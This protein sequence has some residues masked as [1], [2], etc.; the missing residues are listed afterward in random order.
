[1]K[2]MTLWLGRWMPLAVLLC[3]VVL[4]ACKR[5][6]YEAPPPPEVTVARPV[7]QD[8]TL[9][10]E[11]TGTT[12]AVEAADVRAR[13]KGFLVSME[14][15]PGQLVEQD[16]LLFVI[17]PQPFEVALKAAQAELTAHRAEMDL[18]QTEYER[19]DQ[20]YKRKATSEF[21]VVKTRANYE[22]AK[23]A[24]LESEANVQSAQL[25]LDYAHVKA[26]FAGRVDRHQVDVGNLVG[27]SEA[28]LLTKLVRY[29][30]IYVYF[31]ISE[32][33]LL[34]L[35]DLG[36]RRRPERDAAAG[37]R[38]PIP[39]EV[40]RANDT[41]YPF[42]GVIDFTANQ[43]DANT[44]TFEVRGVLPNFE[45]S[46]EVIVPGTFVRVRVPIDVRSDSML[47]TERALG[48]DQGGRYLLVVGEDDIVE[49]RTVEVGQS[50]GGMRVIRSG[51]EPND[52]VVVNGLQRAR[53]GAAVRP[54]Q[55]VAEP[56]KLP[57]VIEPPP[58]A[59]PLATQTT[60]EADTSAVD[61]VDEEAADDALDTA[62]DAPAAAE[63]PSEP[64][65]A[66]TPP[67]EGA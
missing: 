9:Y 33:D 48:A 10:L 26:P 62:V 39:I 7:V 31:Y 20:M 4:G 23:A 49:H 28:T 13:V 46:D 35:Q 38:D 16:Q 17:D 61:P 34:S 3:V 40:G 12:R 24:V 54:E 30:P 64:E 42:R 22:K 18:A 29:D 32:R 44:G 50:V 8:V 56:P 36:L 27:A 53:P 1:M 45:S 14:F 66:H 47:V 52:W 6:E 43:L 37:P 21:N 19:T 2:T 60:G 59:E 5:N 51:I 15:T 41:G 25:D 58:A 65:A 11:Y 57:P 63:P 67:A 55:T